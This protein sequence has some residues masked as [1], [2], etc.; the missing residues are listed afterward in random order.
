M[1]QVYL[2]CG[3]LKSVS[4]KVLADTEV[5]IATGGRAGSSGTPLSALV[6]RQHGWCIFYKRPRSL[7]CS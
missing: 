7:D 6:W 3:S 1:P 5:H 2:L 4:V